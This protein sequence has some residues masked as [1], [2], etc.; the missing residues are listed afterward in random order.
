MS[1]QSV[2]RHGQTRPFPA[3]LPLALLSLYAILGGAT[4]TISKIAFAAGVSP[5]AYTFWQCAGAAVVMAGI[6]WLKGISLPLERG[7]LRFYVVCGLVGLALPNI[8]MFHSLARLPA[9][10][11]AVVVSTVPVFTCALSNALSVERFKPRRA[12]GIAFGVAGALFIL[13]PRVGLSSPDLSLWI[14]V[15]FLAPFLYAVTHIYVARA[16]PD[17]ASA[18]AITAGMLIVATVALAPIMLYGDIVY[19]PRFPI[20]LAEMMILLQIVIS[21][22]C[23]LTFFAIIRQAGPVFFSQVGYLVTATGLFWAILVFDE[24]YSVWLWLAVGLIFA[25]L[26]LVNDTPW[27]RSRQKAD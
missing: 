14:G 24:S 8:I 10:V 25:G 5:A 4:F 15:A 17:N 6:C 23:Y 16:R 1:S 19:V 7:Y 18:V 3:L 2:V 12:V 20:G 26:A 9:G 27:R 21:S 22:I 11:M 13:L